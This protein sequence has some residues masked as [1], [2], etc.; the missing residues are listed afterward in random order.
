MPL[1]E[2]TCQECSTLFE[3][4]RGV[5]AEAEELVCPGCGSTNV[6]KALS[7]FRAKVGSN[8]SGQAMASP[9]AAARCSAGCACHH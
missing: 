5:T 8:G 9:A 4:L 7:T 2:Y 3:V 1:L 6:E